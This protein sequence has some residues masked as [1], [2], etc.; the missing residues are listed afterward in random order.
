MEDR[1]FWHSCHSSSSFLQLRATRMQLPGVG[2]QHP[3]SS[4]PSYSLCICKS[5]RDTV[6]RTRGSVYVLVWWQDCDCRTWEAKTND[7]G[8]SKDSLGFIVRSRP[9]PKTKQN[10]K[11]SETRLSSQY[12]GGGGRLIRSSRS[13]SIAY[14]SQEQCQL[15]EGLFLKTN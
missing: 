5:L 15:Y 14:W 1:C 3:T 10:S 9:Y 4:H 13:S 7:T 8:D 2:L 11:H 6:K 12:D